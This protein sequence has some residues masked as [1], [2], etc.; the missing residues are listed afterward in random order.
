MNNNAI[1]ALDIGSTKITAIIAQ[2]DLNN[3]INILGVGNLKSNGI[4]KGSIVDINLA[5]DTVNKAIDIAKKS[6]EIDIQKTFVSISSA[7][8]K[9]VRSSG[10]ASI[11]SGQI[12]YNEINQVLQMA[13]YNANIIPEYEAIHVLPLYFKIDDS[14]AIINPLNMYGSRLEVY[15]NIVTVKKTTLINTQNTLKKSNILAT[16]FVLS[17]YASSIAILTNEQKKIGI[18]VFDLGGSTSELT[19][20]Q[21]GTISYNDCIPIGSENIT[22]DLSIMLHTPYKAANMIK[23]QYGTLVITEDDYNISENQTI[24]K[25]KIPLLG[26][27]SESQEIPLTKIQPIIHA[28]I[29]ELLILLKDKLISSN[30][31]E[32][33][34]GGIVITGGMSKTIGIKELANKIFDDIPIKIST[35]INIGNGYIDFNNPA[36]ST[37]VGLLQYALD[38]DPFFEIDSN[39]ELRKKVEKQKITN[40]IAINTIKQEDTFS[41]IDIKDNIKENTLWDKLGK[42]L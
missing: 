12:T 39:K 35:P 38:T 29:E 18:A 27:E 37:I 3:R 11:Q 10:V 36:L 6:C 1:L 30:M 34:N 19:V 42:W 2:N 13:L 28:R 4:N 32:H 21:N 5:S 14:S 9:S 26:N 22:S 31:L 40:D 25:V 20:F 8:S 17:G 16:N 41:S 33:I 7:N 15:V 24:S 23:N